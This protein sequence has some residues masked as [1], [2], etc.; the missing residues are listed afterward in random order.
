MIVYEVEPAR[1]RSG[2]DKDAEKVD[3]VQSEFA[4]T[5]QGGRSGYQ[6]GCSIHLLLESRHSG[7]L[8]AAANY[9]QSI[10][11]RLP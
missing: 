10:A 1:C 2:R 11:G 3:R 8:S 6:K 4:A 5:E 7:V 9:V